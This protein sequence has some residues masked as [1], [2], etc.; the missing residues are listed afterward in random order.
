MYDSDDSYRKTEL[1][2]PQLEDSS[3]KEV[4]KAHLTGVHQAPVLSFGHSFAPKEWFYSRP[5]AL[6]ETPVQD[7]SKSLNK[8][9]LG[10]SHSRHAVEDYYIAKDHFSDEDDDGD[11]YEEVT[12]RLA[13]RQESENHLP[14]SP[15][16]EH[17]TAPQDK[18]LQTS[19]LET[20]TRTT[21][22]F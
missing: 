6:Q 11:P 8:L 13:S 10:A 3:F 19:F 15:S 12:P 17:E 18:R 7:L 1:E 9:D 4:T 5:T 14:I 2:D 20:G 21:S 22:A 16:M